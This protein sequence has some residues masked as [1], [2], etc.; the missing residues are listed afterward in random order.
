LED[1]HQIVHHLFPS[2]N[3]VHLPELVPMIKK[4]CAEFGIP[5]AAQVSIGSAVWCFIHTVHH[6]MGEKA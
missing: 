3:S 1:N 4:T 6:T 5:Y 2:V